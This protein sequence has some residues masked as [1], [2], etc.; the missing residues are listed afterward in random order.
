MPKA[1]VD[2]GGTP[3]FTHAL[4]RL[5]AAPS[6]GTA[7][8]VAPPGELARARAGVERCGPWRCPISVVAGGAER[9]D[10]VRN[11]LAALGAVELIAIH[12]AARPFVS[13]EVVEA[14]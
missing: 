11:G 3:L 1:F 4:R 10:S 13:P 7:V 6:I 14:A 12:D 9:Q 2:L 8:V 5:V